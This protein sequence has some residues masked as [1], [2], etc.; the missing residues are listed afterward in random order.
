MGKPKP[1]TAPYIRNRKAGFKYE[2]LEKIQCGI[3]LLG[4][5]VKSLREGQASL[6]EA[7]ARHH[8]GSIWLRGMNIT[9]YAF[10][11]V[12]NHVA[13]RDRQLL[14]HQEE[15]TRLE[16]QI[17]I[18]GLTLVPLDLHF[19]ERGIVKITLGLVRGKNVADKRQSIRDREDKRALARTMRQRR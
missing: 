7:F 14:L 15:I 16:A 17:K 18:K 9:P 11:N 13:D 6:D 2:I 10:G 5:E 1:K 3:I 4:T 8:R 19:N 12:N